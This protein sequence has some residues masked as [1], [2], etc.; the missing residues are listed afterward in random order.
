MQ[1]EE[2]ACIQ[3]SCYIMLQT[4][5]STR[6]V[7]GP[8]ANRPCDENLLRTCMQ[9]YNGVV[10]GRWRAAHY[11]VRWFDSPADHSVKIRIRRRIQS[12]AAL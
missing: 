2:P 10:V 4:K 12:S 6:W 8:D 1:P 11:R 9:K 3:Q 7:F 5:T